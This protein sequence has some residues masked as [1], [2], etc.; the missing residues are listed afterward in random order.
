MKNKSGKYF[1]KVMVLVVSLMVLAFSG[2]YAYFT[3]N[4]EG[5]TKTTTA[6][7]GVFK[8]ESSLETANAINNSKM[9][10]INESEKD[11]RADA[12]TFTVTS[13]SDTDVDGEFYLYIQDVVL[14]KNFYSKYLKWEILKGNEV[15]SSGSFENAERTDEPQEGEDEKALTTID[16]F[17][18]NEEGINIPKNTTTTYKFRMYLLND[19]NVNQIELTE[20]RF[21]GKLFMEAIPSSQN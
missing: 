11:E 6:T 15:V 10:L 13:S 16:Q 18:L 9:V 19:E 2:T 14:S 1:A 5:N 12:V 20:G 7:S 8:I 4:I 21:E 3:M 17:K